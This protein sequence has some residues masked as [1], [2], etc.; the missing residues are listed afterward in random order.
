MLP[1]PRLHAIN[2][3]D[4]EELPELVDRTLFEE[5]DNKDDDQGVASR[6]RSKT[7]IIGQL[8]SEQLENLSRKAE[9]R[10]IMSLMTITTTIFFILVSIPFWVNDIAGSDVPTIG[11]TQRFKDGFEKT[12]QATLS[13]LKYLQEYDQWNDKKDGM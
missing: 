5:P 13:Q 12:N 7:R 6:T 1:I 8:S 11:E 4:M 10:N 2:A 9:N 3:N